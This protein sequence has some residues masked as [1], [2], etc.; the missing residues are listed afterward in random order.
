MARKKAKG[1][2]CAPC[3]KCGC[4]GQD[5]DGA[6][7]YGK[8]GPNVL[9][10]GVGWFYGAHCFCWHASE[11]DCPVH[12]SPESSEALADLEPCPNAPFTVE[13]GG[14]T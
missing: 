9:K 8:K 4:A 5:S 14:K 7:C 3:C 11:A 10:P 12:G 13:A 6:D 1:C 2:V